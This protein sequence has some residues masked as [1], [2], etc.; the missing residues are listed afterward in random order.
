MQQRKCHLVTLSC[1]VP[2]PFDFLSSVECKK[3]DV[4]QNDKAALFNK[5]KMNWE[6]IGQAQKRTNKQV[7]VTLNKIE[8]NIKSS[9][10]LK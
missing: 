4:R 10:A 6:C 9:E 5:L 3:K 1:H 7:K 2:N 8:Q